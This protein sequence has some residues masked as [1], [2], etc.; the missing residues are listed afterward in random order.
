MASFISPRLILASRFVLLLMC[1]LLLAQAFVSTAFAENSN[2]ENNAQV[3]QQDVKSLFIRLQERLNN[4]EI[5]FE[6]FSS[7]W[8]KGWRKRV[9][10][11]KLKQELKFG[12]GASYKF[13]IPESDAIESWNRGIKLLDDWSYLDS[14][15]LNSPMTRL[16]R[17][18]NAFRKVQWTV[19]YQLQTIT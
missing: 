19:H 18:N 5:V 8:M 17:R 10:E 12:D 3:I 6:V 16:M 9:T 11:Y 15:E 1:A 7:R 13:G 14:E 4:P 2:D